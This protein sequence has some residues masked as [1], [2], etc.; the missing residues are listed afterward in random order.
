MSCGVRGDREWQ[1]KVQS[2]VVV[3]FIFSRLVVG[4]REGEYVWDLIRRVS[5]TSWIGLWNIMRCGCGAVSVI[6][7]GYVNFALPCLDCWRCW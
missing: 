2:V 5:A 6:R 7:S 4:W 1:V 3:V